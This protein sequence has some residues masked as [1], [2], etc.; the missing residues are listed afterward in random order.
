MLSVLL[1]AAFGLAP[2]ASAAHHTTR[3]L[4][5]PSLGEF[6]LARTAP[7]AGRSLGRLRQD[8]LEIH[9]FLVQ[10]KKESPDNGSTTGDGTFGSD[11]R[12][13]Y[14]LE[15]AEHRA[16][17]P[18][19]YF[20]TL[21]RF[22]ERYWEQVSNGHL[23][24][25]FK[26]FPTG[27]SLFYNLDR[28]LSWYSPA[29][30][31][32]GEKAASFDSTKMS[33]FLELVSDASRKAAQDPS[34]PFA[35]PPA[36]SPTRHRGYLLLHAGANSF[37]DG[38]KKGASAI[39]SRSDLN[40]FFVEDSSFQFLRLRDRV[41]DTTHLG[42]SLGV[43]LGAPGLDTLKNVM[44]L[45][46]T[47]SQDGLNW[48]LHGILAN[49]IGRFT[50]LPD[51]W[52]WVRGYSMMGRFCGMDFGG[53]L[54]GG[55][56]FLPTRP[57]AWL[58]LFMG[59]A[60]PVVASPSELRRLRLPP[61]SA[62][63]DTVLV[64]PLNDGE[65]L[66]AEN[67]VRTDASGR[68]RLTVLDALD[69]P[70]Q[71]VEVSPD[72]VELLFRDSLDGKPNPRRLKG[73]IVDATADA[74]LPGSGL[75]V[76]KVDEWLLRSAL[77]Y[78]GPNV[79]RGEEMRDRYRGIRLV[80]ADGI[81][82]L[83]V[84]FTNAAGQTG[85][86]YG[87]G[88][89]M[90]PHFTKKGG[91]K[92]TLVAISPL[93]YASTRNLSDARSLVTLRTRWPSTSKTEGSVSVPS[94]DSVWTPSEA[95]RLELSLDWGPYRDTLA[96]FPVRLPPSEGEAALLPGPE[97]G[98]LWILDTA[99]RTQLLLADGSP[100]FARRDT[101]RLDRSWVGV[102]T[103]VPPGENLDSLAVP[104]QVSG[105]A[106]GRPFGSAMLSDTLVVRTSRGLILRSLVGGIPLRG[107]DT[108]IVHDL[109]V[110][111][112][113]LA[114]PVVV[115]RRAW[116]ATHDSLIGISADGS[117]RAIRIPFPPHDLAEYQID[118]NRY[119]I[120]MVGPGGAAGIADLSSDSVV[121][122]AS[123]GESESDEEFRIAVSDFDRDGSED[124]LALGSRGHALL[125]GRQGALPGWPRR[126]ARGGTGRPDNAPPS[127]ADLDGD[128][129]PEAIFTGDDRVYAVDFR[130]TPLPQWPAR[131]GR[132]EPV[133]LATASRLWPA[134]FI[135]SS[136]LPVDLDGDG[137]PEVLVGLPDARIAALSG[138]A[139]LYAGTLQGATAGA[140]ASPS[141]G[142]SL[143]PLAAGGRPGDTVRSPVL[144]IALLPA[145]GA[146]P[147]HLHG[148]SSLS[149]LDGFRLPGA[150]SEWMLPR[151]DARRTS[152]L[153]AS[154]LGAASRREKTI[155]QFLIYP[156]PVRDKTATFRW[157]LG[158]SASSVELTVFD[159]TGF[160][161]L[162]RTGLCSSEGTCELPLQD[163][164]WG[165]GVY[166]A[167]LEV[168]WSE[169]GESESWTRFGV[170]R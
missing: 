158:R 99:G 51:T 101:L 76:W 160:A 78:G 9:V 120:A 8:T 58:R 40:D 94:L 5:G 90:L 109:H 148:L 43:V 89:D 70:E 135:G 39:D 97:A 63:S 150:S 129:Y 1:A 123:T 44:V 23:V 13:S 62:G 100:G 81:P 65:F 108:A 170:V 165:T 28:N 137:R 12:H 79:W 98:T 86:D 167:R 141:Y 61:V 117:R 169:G 107:S 114:G 71:I 122:F 144:H 161:I 29:Q 34:G 163:L 47:A 6:S 134:G 131:M 149:T 128:G 64:I 132:T 18:R 27:D 16:D 140:G 87:T 73:F 95:S 7:V 142:Q 59:W 103:V 82:T 102:R 2:T 145:R 155:G 125:S 22:Q 106:L 36:S 92:D 35:A 151:R 52:D 54:L 153:A 130:G 138:K 25:Q 24:V 124:I 118:G 26:I 164:R 60:T 127:L 85:F 66:L 121:R 111:G 147:I 146:E 55:S 112:D 75:L 157:S 105:P 42:D 126:F 46:E 57:S 83:G 77:V 38:G 159:Q 11:K 136:P 14:A 96:A 68:V 152:R 20:Q 115:A 21:L 10:F 15:P 67:R 133:G 104:L 119:G 110:P 69:G 162:S 19:E 80:E 4:P 32:S 113:F 91:K 30:A 154:N 84:A 33:R 3:L 88:A 41:V 53:Y 93:S 168:S 45:S 166:A 156:S 143:W 37:A 74:A 56:G 139:T 48:G 72:S 116:V 17:R 49:Q 31:A 50:G